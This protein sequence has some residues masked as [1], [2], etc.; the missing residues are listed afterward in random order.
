VSCTT[1]KKGIKRTDKSGYSLSGECEI[2]IDPIKSSF[3]LWIVLLCLFHAAEPTL[4]QVA[5]N[6]N[7]FRIAASP[8]LTS[9]EPTKSDAAENSTTKD[10]HAGAGTTEGRDECT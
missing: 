6:R 2:F 4:G 5:A 8:A 10:F 3:G 7:I 1:R 9:L